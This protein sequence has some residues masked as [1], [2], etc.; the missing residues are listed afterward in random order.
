MVITFP[1][2]LKIQVVQNIVIYYK[3]K[4]YC[5][6]ARIKMKLVITPLLIW[7]VK[8]MLLLTLA[9]ISLFPF[10]RSSLG[11][12]RKCF[13]SFCSYIFVVIFTQLCKFCL[14][15]YAFDITF[16]SEM[17]DVLTTITVSSII[18]F[19]L[20][21]WYLLLLLL[22]LPFSYFHHWVNSKFFSSPFLDTFSCLCLDTNNYCLKTWFW[23]ALEASFKNDVHI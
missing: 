16:A 1:C 2:H 5:Q 12:Y 23:S 6:K 19:Y 15:W 17:R 3:S 9:I 8:K 11:E 20:C 22:S 10:W 7:M 21:H 14:W 18:H 13:F 4:I